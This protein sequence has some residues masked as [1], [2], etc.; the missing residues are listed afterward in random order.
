MKKRIRNS[1]PPLLVLLMCSMMVTGQPRSVSG[2]VT[3]ARD[4]MPVPSA[5]VTIKGTTTGTITDLD[6]NW[7]LQINGNDDVLLFS[8]IGYETLEETVG[9]RTEINVTL[10]EEVSLLDEIVVVGYGVQKKSDLT[11]AI[12]QV[13]S[14]E[15]TES[16]V[17]GIDQALQGR[18]AGVTITNNSGM[19][20]DG[21][22][23][24]IRGMGTWND[25]DPLYVVDGMPLE[26]DISFINPADI[27]TIEVLKDA[28]AAAIYGARAANGVILVTTKTGTAN[29]NQVSFDAYYGI[30]DLWREVNVTDGPGY[31]DVY[32][33]FQVSAGRDPENPI[34]QERFFIADSIAETST[35]WQREIFRPAPIQ[36]YNLTV[37]GGNDRVT[38]GITGNYINQQGIMLNTGYQRFSFRANTDVKITD[39]LTFGERFSIGYSQS[40]EAPR[41]GGNAPHLVAL[42]GDPISPVYREEDDPDYDEETARWGELSYSRKPN[43]VGILER[44]DN[45][46]LKTPVLLNSYLEYELLD[47]LSVR[48]NGGL[49][50]LF[51][52][53]QAFSQTYY[54]GGF[55][56]NDLTQMIKRNWK[57]LSWLFETTV[58]YN[59][60][61]GDNH[62]LNVMAGFSRQYSTIEDFMA[63]KTDFPGNDQAYRYLTFGTV[64]VLPSD[65]TATKTESAIESQFGRVNY[66][67]S[68]KYLVTASLRRDGS[69][70]FGPESEPLF[71]NTPRYD[72]FPS[73]ALAWKI[74]EENFLKDNVEAINFLKLRLGWG[75]LGN[76]RTILGNDYPWFSAVETNRNLQNY[77]FGGEIVTGGA[78]VG[79]AIRDIRWERSSQWNLGLDMNLFKNK[80]TFTGDLYRK[81]TRD[82]LVAVPLPLIVGIFNNPEDTK[83]GS[84]PL[85]NAGEVLNQGYEFILTYRERETALKYSVSVNFSHNHNEVIA[86][87]TGSEQILSGRVEGGSASITTPGYPIA[88]FWGFQTDGLYTAS[89]DAD[90]DGFAE[91]QTFT[92][93]ENGD[94]LYLQRNAAPGDLK[95]A[96]LEN[97][98]ILNAD[99]KTFIGSPHPDF[100]FGLNVSLEFRGFD[101]SMFWQGVYGNEI[102]SNLVYD[103]LGGN[104]STNFHADILN[105]Y[106]LP[107][108]E[109][110]GNTTTGIP[111]IDAGQTNQ[112]FRPSDFYVQDGSYLRLKTIQLGYSLP[113]KVCTRIG[114][115]GIRI[116][117]SAQ[118]LLT[119]TNYKYG[120]DPEIGRAYNDYGLQQEKYNQNMLD[121]AIDKGVYPQARTLMMG[122]NI[123]F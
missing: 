57:N 71:G 38:Y 1:I 22:M 23:V 12:T 2:T 20:G 58:N 28:S 119:F 6:G 88:S 112:N 72:I 81:I 30:Q 54:E 5:N 36:N 8:F 67:F 33:L 82:Q 74:S 104:P 122:L 47:G 114:F 64:V 32:N 25:S 37:S 92:I 4:G 55:S 87:G 11:G 77:V 60:T 117:A 108:G 53:T 15:L 10:R 93:R 45:Q 65:I 39:R 41:G 51:H 62:H 101:F 69:S 79:K 98:S 21:V 113:H 9:N 91:N 48:A 68:D 42:L 102:Y 14:E 96:D 13:R 16:A 31:K 50:M 17:L 121:M 85:L 99:D 70:R 109:D 86:L 80:I 83:L 63:K 52:E 43:P 123:T 106:R 116:Y 7:T 49:N 24:N 84:D 27:E 61:F 120:Y 90:G 40:E 3:D 44:L 110:P 115:S 103:F 111:R 95:F 56:K 75:Q 78:I 118:N 35:N 66:A 105:A 73:A 76:D 19:P 97:D 26:N 18:A 34:D 107:S 89:D 46:R 29:R 94:T 100:T 59:K